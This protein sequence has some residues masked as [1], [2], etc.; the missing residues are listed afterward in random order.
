MIGF[1]IDLCRGD[2]RGE[3]ASDIQPA[4]GGERLAQW[5]WNDEQDYE[6]LASKIQKA[7]ACGLVL[8]KVYF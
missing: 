8:E 2:G 7:A 5:L 3:L 1:L 6:T 4:D